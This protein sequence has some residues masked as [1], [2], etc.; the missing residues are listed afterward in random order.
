MEKKFIDKWIL[1]H[2]KGGP[3]K[4]VELRQDLKVHF[5]RLRS[6]NII[7]NY[8]YSKQRRQLYSNLENMSSDHIMS[9]DMSDDELMS[10]D[11]EN[12]DELA[13]DIMPSHPGPGIYENTI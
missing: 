2:R 8:W 4:W 10:D 5:C 7:K 12:V 13:D 9:D 3:I 6:E 11:D 1:N